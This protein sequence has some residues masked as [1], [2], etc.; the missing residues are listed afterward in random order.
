MEVVAECSYDEHG[1]NFPAGML[2][3]CQEEHYNNY[4]YHFYQTGCYQKQKRI[5]ELANLKG[6]S[7]PVIGE[8]GMTQVDGMIFPA[9]GE[10]DMTS[11]GDA[12]GPNGSKASNG[13][14]S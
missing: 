10:D 5:E 7:N 8:Q 14:L 3:K 4:M 2:E 11:T 9:T 12:N 13:N 1:P 6:A